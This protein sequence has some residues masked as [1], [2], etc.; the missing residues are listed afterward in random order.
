[1]KIQNNRRIAGDLLVG[2]KSIGVFGLLFAVVG[3][4]GVDNRHATT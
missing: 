4:L 3:L 2:A 1:M